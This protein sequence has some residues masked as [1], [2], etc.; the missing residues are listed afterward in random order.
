MQI[1]IQSIFL[2][3]RLKCFSCIDHFFYV[4]QCRF[5]H[6]RQNKALDYIMTNF[7]FKHD[8]FDILN[9]YNKFAQLIF[10]SPFT[11]KVN[12]EGGLEFHT[13]KTRWVRI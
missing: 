5:S 11:L 3:I 13:S 1:K 8:I 7:N 2:S 9:V 10:V 12:K 4:G 6:H